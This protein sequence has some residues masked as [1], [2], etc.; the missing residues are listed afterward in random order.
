M[1]LRMRLRRKSRG[2]SPAIRAL[3]VIALIPLLPGCSLGSDRVT[4]AQQIGVTRDGGNIVVVVYTC[5]TFPHASRVAVTVH[6]L[7]AKHDKVLWEVRAS[8]EETG[9]ITTRFV[10]GATPPS[11]YQTSVPRTQ[12]LPAGELDVAIARGGRAAGVMT[13]R[14]SDLRES[15]LRVDSSWFSRHSEVSLA[16]FTSTN[17]KQCGGR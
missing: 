13:F 17:E 14:I 2:M 9:P 8:R 3:I 7:H 10:V 5:P 6:D 12:T 16:H 4:G 15:E 11:G 1:L